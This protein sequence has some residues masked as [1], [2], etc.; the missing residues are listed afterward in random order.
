MTGDSEYE[1]A[2]KM[3]EQ[4]EGLLK[5]L[6][7]VATTPAEAGILLCNT[8]RSLMIVFGDDECGARTLDE[9]T[10]MF[11]VLHRQAKAGSKG[12]PV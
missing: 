10:M 5:S 11:G 12:K 7:Y 4:V 8:V 1:Q 6:R 2:E 3:L 9:I